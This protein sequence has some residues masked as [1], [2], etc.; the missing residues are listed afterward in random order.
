MKI[1]FDNCVDFD[2][3]KET[4]LILQLETFN[5][6]GNFRTAFCLVEPSSIP[7]EEMP[8]LTRLTELHVAVVE[9]WNKQDYPTVLFT[10]PHLT[11]KF[12]GELDSFYEI[13]QERISKKP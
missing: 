13:L 2:A 5:F 12:G 11:G 9:A 3:I 8:D 4:Y 10:L 6:E 1:V 7:A